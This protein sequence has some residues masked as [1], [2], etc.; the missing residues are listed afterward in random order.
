MPAGGQI[1]V[2][3]DVHLHNHARWGGPLVGGINTRGQICLDVLGHAIETAKQR[4][5][6]VFV[7]AG[8]LFHSARP[9][10]V[11]IE[12]V[13]RLFGKAD[14]PVYLVPGNHDMSDATAEAG[15]TALAPLWPRAEVITNPSEIPG[16]DGLP[17]ILMVPFQADVP[18]AQHLADTLPL[19]DP[20]IRPGRP[21]RV[22]I[23]HV[24]VY[25]EE[26]AQDW[27]RR[28]K[29]AISTADL[30]AIMERAGV[31]TAVVGNYHDPFD[32][33]RGVHD[34]VYRIVQAGTLCPAGFGDSDP[35]HLVLLNASRAIERVVPSGQPRFLVAHG[36]SQAEE[37]ARAGHQFLFLRQVGGDRIEDDLAARCFAYDLDATQDPPAAAPPAAASTTQTPEQAIASHIADTVPEDRR[38]SVSDLVGKLWRGGAR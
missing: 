2:V 18:M 14:M 17:P 20:A 22:L 15:N 24:G 1:A 9:D 13:Q 21:W 7:V 12:R 28:A 23:T 36:R 3:A 27:Q 38:D 19:F 10:P 6:A 37:A 30:F 34:Q 33:E 4:G 11:L 8:D 35:G 26:R 31:H 32:A 16:R 25:Q 5:A 29:D